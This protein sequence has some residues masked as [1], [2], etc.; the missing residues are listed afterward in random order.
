[1]QRREQL[2]KILLKPQNCA[3]LDRNVL[4]LKQIILHVEWECSGCYARLQS[5]PVWLPFMPRNLEK[6]RVSEGNAQN[7]GFVTYKLKD[8]QLPNN[9]GWNSTTR[10]Q[11]LRLCRLYKDIHIQCREAD[12]VFADPELMGRQKDRSIQQRFS[13]KWKYL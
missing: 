3:I 13:A 1:M 8:F 7:L 11:D 4:R 6:M 2:E 5:H 9:S 12:F 10:H